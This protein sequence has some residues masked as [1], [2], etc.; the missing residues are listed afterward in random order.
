MTALRK[1]VSE[2]SMRSEIQAEH[3]RM[4]VWANRLKQQQQISLLTC[5]DMVELPKYT[6]LGVAQH[7]DM[8]ADVTHRRSI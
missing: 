3:M 7:R 8:P 5:E 4:K 1:G 6:E 2:E